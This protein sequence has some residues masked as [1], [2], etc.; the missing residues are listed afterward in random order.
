[1]PTRPLDHHD[2]AAAEADPPTTIARNALAAGARL[3]AAAHSG[4]DH[5]D[6]GLGNRFYRF[7]RAEQRRFMSRLP[8]PNMRT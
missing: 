8:D 1:M 7:S 4:Q 2:A 5:P 6:S 3:N